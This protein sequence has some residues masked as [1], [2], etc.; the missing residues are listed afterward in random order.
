MPSLLKSEVTG[1]LLNGLNNCNIIKEIIFINNALLESPLFKN[2]AKL[3]VITPPKNLYV[4]AS[5][6]LGVKYSESN[7]IVLCNDDINFEYEKIETII[8]FL[9][10][11]KGIVGVSENCINSCSK[12]KIKFEIAEHRNYGYGTLMI[13]RKSNYTP[14]PE[15]LKIW[16]GDDYLFYRQ[17]GFNY[18]VDGIN[19]KTNMSTTSSLNEFDEIKKKDIE[20]YL[21]YYLKEHSPS[22]KIFFK[23]KKILKKAE[24]FKYNKI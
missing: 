24:I 2:F 22:K 12:Y 6:N 3:R 23:M 8:D 19:L 15:D 16:C 21:K 7:F 5:W 13:M 14:I 11:K 10:E 17:T 1:E 20:T 4:N 18:K 9:H